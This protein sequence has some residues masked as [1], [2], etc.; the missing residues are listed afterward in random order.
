ML[1]IEPNEHFLAY[2]N[3]SNVDSAFYKL[4]VHWFSIFWNNFRIV[5]IP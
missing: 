5:T 2:V 4:P 1:K 3:I